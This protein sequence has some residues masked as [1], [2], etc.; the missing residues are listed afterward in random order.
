MTIN[1]LMQLAGRYVLGALVG[2]LITWMLV[3]NYYDA[4]TDALESRWNESQSVIATALATE[5]LRTHRLREEGQ[6]E[7][8]TL[9]SR[10]RA[11][12]R[13]TRFSGLRLPGAASGVSAAGVSGAA[14]GADG[15]AADDV[16][17]AAELRQLR[18]DLDKVAE[19]GAMCAAQ[20]LVWQKW[21][22]WVRE[23]AYPHPDT[24]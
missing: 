15:A 20:V 21:Y 14:A 16:S 2:A 17:A 19:D 18:E 8:E 22:G 23:G 12:Y 11:Y 6:H 13:D 4:R 3:A 1:P 5:K 24:R 7:L 10:V 9:R